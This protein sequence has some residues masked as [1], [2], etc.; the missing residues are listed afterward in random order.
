M[1]HER[2]MKRRQFLKGTF[3]AA[4]FVALAGCD[5]L[6]QTAGSFDL[7]SDGETDRTSA[8][9]RHTLECPLAKEYGDADISKV[10]P[11]NGSTDPGT[12]AMPNTWRNNS[13]NGRWR[14]AAWFRL[15]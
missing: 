5:N 12:E 3:G 13:P 8:T 7:E 6:T 2:A 14:S 1:K 10:F 11:A 9:G 15:R 4:S